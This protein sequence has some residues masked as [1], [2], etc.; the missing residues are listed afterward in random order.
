[1]AKKTGKTPA[2]RT[3]TLTIENTF[4]EQESVKWIFTLLSSTLLFYLVSLLITRIYSP[5]VNKTLDLANQL[6]IFNESLFPE[7]MEKLLYISGIIIFSL[8]IP[9]AYLIF[10]RFSGKMKS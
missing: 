10:Q 6:T 9:A 5:D 7:P 4:I 3:E 1:M 8:S 2:K